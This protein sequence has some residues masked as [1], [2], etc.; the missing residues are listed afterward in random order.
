[1][2]MNVCVPSVM[3]FGAARKGVVKNAYEIGLHE[4]VID[5]E[6]VHI[7][8]IAIIVIIV[9]SRGRDSSGRALDFH[10]ILIAL[11]FTCVSLR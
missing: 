3:V 2:C 4:V 10:C 7:G 11:L 5:L 8:D 9:I 1:M 6:V